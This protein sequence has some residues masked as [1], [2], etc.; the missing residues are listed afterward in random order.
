M[1]LLIAVHTTHLLHVLV[2]S[3]QSAGHLVHKFG[4]LTSEDDFELSSEFTYA[5][6]RGGLSLPTLSTVFFVHSASTLYEKLGATR[7]CCRT[8]V[9][10][11]FGYIASPWAENV[12]A[13]KTLANILLKACV[14]NNSDR[15]RELGCLRRKEKLTK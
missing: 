15:E 2:S 14:L 10:K 3:C 1:T 13:C 9:Q 11:S 5:L 8:Y 6:D 12:P 4:G 7:R